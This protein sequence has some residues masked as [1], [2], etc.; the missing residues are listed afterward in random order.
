VADTGMGVAAED[1]QRIFDSFQQGTRPAGQ[2]EGTGLGL[3]LSKRIVE[4]H[5][6]RIWLESEVGTGSTFGFTLPA[7]S[8][9]PVSA[10]VPL[11]GMDTGLTTKPAPGPGPTVVVVEDDRRSFDLLRA[12]L[13]AAGVRV[14]GA[15]DG[16]EGLDTVRRLS[17]AGVIL[18]ILLPGIDGWEVLARLKADPRTA[19]IP[20]I[21][22][23]MLDERGRGFALG[24]AEYLVKPVGKE[25]LLAAVYRAAAMPERE[26]TVV[27]IDDDPR[28]IKLVRANLE[29]EGWTVLGAPTGREGL[30][31]I[32]ERQPSVVLLDLLMP[33]MDG[34]EVVEELRAE[35]GTKTIPVVILT[36][37]SMT[38][39]DKERLRGRI[40]YVAR[41]TEFDLSGLAGLLRWASTSRQSPAPEPG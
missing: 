23:S 39:Q 37:K 16:E 14:V 34:F 26:H 36:S 5:G 3:T 32:R 6:G 33:G 9:E 38:P 7:G 25:P 28:V 24:A 13:E 30:A 10:P 1:H 18:D 20:V 15:R 11:A 31:L 41:K 29:P 35:P 17:P 12:H 8:E 27:A 22:V 19:P 2:A 4:L 21:V 40:T